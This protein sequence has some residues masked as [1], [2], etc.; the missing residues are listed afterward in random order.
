MSDNRNAATAGSDEVLLCGLDGTNPLGFLAALGAF[1]LL[2][3]SN[4]TLLMLWKQADGTW[5]PAFRSLGVPVDQLGSTLFT[6][7]G[8]LDKAVWSLDKKLPFA[9]ERLRAEAARAAAT[10]TTDSR[11]TCDLLAS[12]GVE[13][14][15][16][17]KGDFE[18]TA[19]RLVRARDS[20]GQGLL[21]YGKRILEST[22]AQELQDTVMFVWQHQDKQCALRWDPTED[23]GYALQWRDP[24]EVGAR[25]VRGGNCLALMAMPMLPTVPAGGEVQTVGFG[26]REPKQISFTWPIWSVPATIDTARSLLSL[27]I[28]QKLQPDRT[29]LA[30]RRIQGAYRSNRVMTSTY[31]ANFTP[32]V[33]VA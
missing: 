27:P 17:D 24:R 4:P 15:R 6:V 8:G 16:D 21:A 14:C 11:E 5:R 18:D 25:S 26:L 31:Y 13:C 9:G 1:R 22:T 12:L 23:K 30:L 2:A 3:A 19:L 10:A 28:L 32:S 20:T 29:E 7:L 33:R